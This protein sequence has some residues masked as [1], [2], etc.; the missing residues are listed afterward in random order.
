MPPP[1]PPQ[2]LPQISKRESSPPYKV[3]RAPQRTLQKKRLG[4][5][6]VR[7][8][9]WSPR[10][11]QETTGVT[12]LWGIG[13][14]ARWPLLAWRPGLARASLYSPRSLEP[15]GPVYTL[16]E[17]CGLQEGGK[18][19]E[20]RAKTSICWQSLGLHSEEPHPLPRGSRGTEQSYLPVGRAVLWDQE[21]PGGRGEQQ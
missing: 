8:E 10:G 15:L 11:Y 2:A 1:P 19:C 4:G 13:D 16:L 17:V 3:N 5:Y 9:C 18:S 7:T 12:G 6:L 21:G 20:V 14:P